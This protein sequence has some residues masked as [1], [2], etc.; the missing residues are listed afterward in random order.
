MTQKEYFKEWYENHKEQRAIYN[1]KWKLLY[2]THVE[3]YNRNYYKTHRGKNI[4]KRKSNNFLKILL[5][6]LTRK[7]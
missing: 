7:N 3:E 4:R 5:L 6:L 2:P 1:H